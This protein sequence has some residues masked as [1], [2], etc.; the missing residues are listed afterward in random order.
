MTN[1]SFFLPNSMQLTYFSSG[2]GHKWILW[3]SYPYWFVL[4]INLCCVDFIKPV[5]NTGVRSLFSWKNLCSTGRRSK[6]NA[7]FP[8]A[9]IPSCIF[10]DRARKRNFK[11]SSGVPV[12][13]CATAKC[14]F[15]KDNFSGGRTIRH[16][17]YQFQT[18][19]FMTSGPSG[20][21]FG[22]VH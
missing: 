18:S 20:I 7:P 9:H 8:R 17:R 22:S 3:V 12:T 19:A 5:N 4:S 10:P 1:R 21:K 14:Q 6:E 11:G 15:Q 16:C 13:F 2:L